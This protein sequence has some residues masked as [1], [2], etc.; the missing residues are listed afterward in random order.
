[1]KIRTDSFARYLPKGI[2]FREVRN[3]DV[4]RIVER[5]NNRP[6]K[7]LGFRTPNEAFFQF[8]CCF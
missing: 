4:L 2:D 1:M 8:A 6:R 7:C 5:L 3:D